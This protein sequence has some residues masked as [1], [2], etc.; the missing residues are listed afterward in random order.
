MIKSQQR[1]QGEMATVTKAIIDYVANVMFTDKRLGVNNIP[2]L[3]NEGASNPEFW[4]ELTER[5]RA[6]AENK[7]IRTWHELEAADPAPSDSSDSSTPD[8][9]SAGDTVAGVAAPLYDIPLTVVPPATDEQIADAL[10][11]FAAFDDSEYLGVAQPTRYFNQRMGYVPVALRNQKT[12]VKGHK[13]DE[14]RIVA[15][16]PN[17]QRLKAFKPFTVENTAM[18]VAPLTIVPKVTKAGLTRWLETRKRG[19]A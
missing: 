15:Q 5:Q 8:N 3:A 11:P 6:T 14:K 16:I 9:G 12:A 13:S 7:I 17:M 10:L 19:A 2:A 1:G 4:H 18:P